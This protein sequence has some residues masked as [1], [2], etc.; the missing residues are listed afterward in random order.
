MSPDRNLLFGILALQNSFV[1][2]EQLLAAFD[3]WVADKSRALGDVLVAQGALQPAARQALDLLASEHVA[4]HGGDAR[5]SLAAVGPARPVHEGLEHL[6]DPDVQASLA[7]LPRGAD[8]GQTQSYVG[9][10]T[11]AG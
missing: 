4:R 9:Q 2:R 8:P 11:S 1:T 6:A 3:A 7:H 5:K 10:A